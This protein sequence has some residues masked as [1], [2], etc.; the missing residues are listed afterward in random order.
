MKNIKANIIQFSVLGL[1][2]WFGF[3]QIAKA[4]TIQIGEKEIGV[5]DYE[6]AGTMQAREELKK[7]VWDLRKTQSF[8]NNDFSWNSGISPYASGFH[9][10]TDYACKRGEEIRTIKEGNVIFAGY[11]STGFGNTVMVNSGGTLT[12][13]A[14]LDR[15]FISEGM[16]LNENQ[17][18]G[19]CGT[20]G[21]STGDH[22]HLECRSNG[23]LVDCADYEQNINN[24]RE[25]AI[26][27]CWQWRPDERDCDSLY[28]EAKD[29]N[30]DY[31]EGLAVM[32]FHAIADAEKQGMFSITDRK[33]EYVK[34]PKNDILRDRKALMRLYFQNL[35]GKVVEGT[36]EQKTVT[37][38]NHSAQQ[39]EYMQYAYEISGYDKEF[40][41]MLKAECGNI[42]PRCQEIGT[43]NGKG[44][45]QH[46]INYQAST[47][48]DPRFFTDWKWQ[49]NQCYSLYDWGI[50]QGNQKYT[51][52]Y[53]LT[54]YWTEPWFRS[55]IEKHFLFA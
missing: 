32:N 29:L 40:L 17:V 13:Y 16:D 48:S 8:L 4:W 19:E 43:G 24:Y 11:T 15:I 54:R 28:N 31:F 41:Y 18:I 37:L 44:F 42:D 14:H 21:F 33:A 50:L 45:C 6:I 55:Q 26:T 49:M 36:G 9:E 46:D 30:I 2:F 39:N 23:L 52:F 35:T 53:G 3:G 10:G 51:M 1:M 25:K 7:E 27:A 47:I 5:S 38:I 22:L 12:K 20:T 34:K